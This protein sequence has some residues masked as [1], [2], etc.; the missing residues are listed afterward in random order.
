MQLLKKSNQLICN[1]MQM[2]TIIIYIKLVS[3]NFDL[4]HN[5]IILE[6]DFMYRYIINLKA[7]PYIYVWV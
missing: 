2:D 6:R 1:K 7:V 4:N 3:G 5:N